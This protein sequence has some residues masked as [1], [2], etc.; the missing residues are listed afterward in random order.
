MQ[1]GGH[2]GH[3]TQRQG[4]H[5]GRQEPRQGRNSDVLAAQDQQ[6]EFNRLG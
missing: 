2:L 5:Q 6:G 3:D 4:Y 1:D